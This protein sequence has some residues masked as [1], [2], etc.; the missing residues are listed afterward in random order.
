MMHFVGRPLLPL[1]VVGLLL[2]GCGGSSPNPTAAQQT[3]GAAVDAIDAIPV[4]AIV[5]D[6]DRYLGTRVPLDGRIAGVR[7][8][9]CGL[10]LAT[11]DGPPLHVNA[12]R[13]G[14]NA[15]TWQVPS[16]TEGVVVATG[17]LRVGADRL[18]L[19]ANGI[20]VTPLKVAK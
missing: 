9:G 13:S 12:A 3:Y 16:G 19:T 10:R 18:R 17:T 1:I 11:N 20:H 4:P 15:C 14:E 5:A 2:S 6:R 8:D 7:R